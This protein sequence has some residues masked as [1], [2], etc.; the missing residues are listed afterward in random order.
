MRTLL[1]IILLCALLFVGYRT[2]VAAPSSFPVPYHLSVT[3]GDTSSAI[4]RQLADDGVIRSRR[5]FQFFMIMLGNDTH[6]SEG[7][8]YFSQPFNAIDIALRISGKEFGINKV[9]VT[10][11]EGYTNDQMT[12]RL[13]ATFPTFDAAG[14]FKETAGTQGYLFPDTY[15]FFPTPTADEVVT[16][17]KDNFQA[18]L[19]PLQADIAASGHSESDIIIMASIIQKEAAGTED[20]PII[21]GILWK[22]ISNGMDLQVDAAPSTY[23]HKGLPDA[24]INN[25]GLVAILAAIHPTASDYLYYLHDAAGNVHYAST[26]AEHQQNIK[27]YLK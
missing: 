16:T 2:F 22:R 7:E 26:F 4:S 8:Y 10:F 27:K 13:V 17:M 12:A 20:S 23:D 21:A 5:V 18:K 1:G 25:P 15:K 11:P 14:F 6:I 24:P 9:K 19:V 3:A